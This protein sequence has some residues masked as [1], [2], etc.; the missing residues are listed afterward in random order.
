MKF[1]QMEKVFDPLLLQIEEQLK[2]LEDGTYGTEETS[3]NNFQVNMENRKMGETGGSGQSI[4]GDMGHMERLENHERDAI[5][6]LRRT[7]IEGGRGDCILH[8]SAIRVQQEGDLTIKG[9]INSIIERGKNCLL[10]LVVRHSDHYH[11]IHDCK[12]SNGSCRCFGL[13][14]SK[15]HTT[16]SGKRNTIVT[17]TEEEFE[18]LFLYHLQ[19]GRKTIFY[20]FGEKSGKSELP[21]GF[22]TI[23]YRRYTE[24]GGILSETGGTMETCSSENEVLWGASS[25]QRYSSSCSNSDINNS[26]YNKKES[27]RTRNRRLAAREKDKEAEKIATLIIKLCTSPVENCFQN[28][29]WT[30]T[31]YKFMDTS[32]NSIRKAL[33][34]VNRMFYNMNLK[35]IYN[36]YEQREE[37]PLWQAHTIETFDE[38]YFDLDT[39][40]YKCVQLI[41][42]QENFKLDNNYE[43]PDNSNWKPVLYEF[44][45][46]LINF[47]DKRTGKQNC[48]YFISPSCSGKSFFWDMIC[49]Y[50][51]LTGN[52]TNWNRSCQFPLQNCVDKK[53]ILWN[54]P[55]CEESSLESLKKITGGEPYSANIKNKQHQ[56]I[57]RT[58]IVV[59]A[60]HIVFPNT[61]EFNSR[62]RYFY[63]K[64]APF[65]LSN[66]S[67][68]LHPMTFHELIKKAMNYYQED[69]LSNVIELV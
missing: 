69:I 11:V 19:E 48:W 55:N 39:S 31:T 1:I 64:H 9:A 59:T 37:T 17:T 14:F 50:M 30:Q 28:I 46:N 51:L 35:D 52:M 42:Y 45:R 34:Y 4:D 5:G 62:V 53:L 47:L 54:E 13:L 49:D 24:P 33:N 44:V 16:R 58:P 38:T 20:K 6:E 56:L 25:R 21:P 43:I 68:R 12:S 40:I 18:N 60:N 29:A 32:D 57:K 61:P 26:Q 3:S 7:I 8:S 41:L 23:Q 22:E 65:L 15:L 63:W 10:K 2:Q 66:K 36:F 67:Y 27:W